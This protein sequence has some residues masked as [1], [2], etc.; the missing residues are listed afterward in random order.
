MERLRAYAVSL[1]NIVDLDGMV[2]RIRVRVHKYSRM[3]FDIA[4]TTLDN[5]FKYF[6][7]SLCCFVDVRSVRRHTCNRI[8]VAYI[9]MPETK[10]THAKKLKRIKL[11][12]FKL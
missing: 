7:I 8:E 2:W 6:V 9:V 10:H 4:A 11:V 1:V 12:C 3:E 5:L